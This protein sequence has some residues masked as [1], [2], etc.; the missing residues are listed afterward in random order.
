VAAFVPAVRFGVGWL[1]L[2]FY[3]LVPLIIYGQSLN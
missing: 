3:A 1:G 2:A